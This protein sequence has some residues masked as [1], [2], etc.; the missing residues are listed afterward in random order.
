MFR[1]CAISL[2]LALL[3]VCMAYAEK[4]VL[5]G[6]GAPDPSDVILIEHLEGLGLEVESHSHDEPQPLDLNGVDVVFISATVSSGN[7]GSFYADST[8]PV[9]NCEAWT[10]DDMGFSV[11]QFDIDGDKI[12]I[13]DAD[14]PIAQGFSGE[15][16]IHSAASEIMSASL[17]GDVTVVAVRTDDPAQ[18]TI[19][20]YEAGATTLIGETKAIHIT[21]FPHNE[22]WTLMTDD[23]WTLIEQSVLYAIGRH[24]GSSVEPVN[25]LAVTWSSIKKR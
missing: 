13:V 18:A 14:H 10:Y 20:V 2:I 16:T 7:I 6:S 25:K 21:L 5:I 22:S 8:V 24:E 17:E 23:G 4:V 12:A 15:V 3:L 1:L 9:I 11:G 19:G